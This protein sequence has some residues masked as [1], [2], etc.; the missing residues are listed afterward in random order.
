MPNHSEFSSRCHARIDL[1]AIEHNAV[2]LQSAWGEG[3]GLMG[4][5]K[6]NAYGHGVLEV[7][8]ALAAHVE[9]FA[10]AGLDEALQLK[11]TAANR[12]KDI[13]LLGAVL[14]REREAAVENGLL[15]ALS[16][17]EEAAAF[18]AIA[19]AQK[20]A[21]RIHLAVDTGMGRIGVGEA[22]FGAFLKKI[23]GFE[24]LSVEGL[25]S[26]FSVADEG[27]PEFTIGQIARFK[28]MAG[29][30]RDCFPEAK[31]IH[32]A[33]SAGLLRFSEHLDFATLARTGLALYGVAPGGFGQDKLKPALQWITEVSLIRELAPGQSISYGRTFVTSREPSTRV[34]VLAAGYGDG[35]PRH[36]SNTGAEVL[37]GGRRCPLLGTVTMDQ[38]MVDVSEL[39]S[40]E[41]GEQAV[42]IGRQGAEEITASEIAEKAGTIPWEIFTGISQRVARIY[43]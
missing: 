20:T 17:L 8:K 15:I 36:L 14:Q 19:A 16:N 38:I 32:I 3:H 10:V 29:L 11:Q 40:V 22:E 9:M 42:L 26:H 33:N 6:A 12:G 4:I 35:Y 37:I 23:Q 30:F 18:D 34:A 39:P 43:C 5:V 31:H 2:A 28:A 24:H 21:A 25:F 1:S 13:F 7:A 27:D 41:V